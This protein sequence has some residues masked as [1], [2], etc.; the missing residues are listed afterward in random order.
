MDDLYSWV[1]LLKQMICSSF[2]EFYNKFQ[3]IFRHEKPVYVEFKKIFQSDSY[4]I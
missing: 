4:T 1:S 2:N 3:Q